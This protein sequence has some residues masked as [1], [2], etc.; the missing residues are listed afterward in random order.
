MA[1][2]FCLRC[3]C[4]TLLL[5]SASVLAVPKADEGRVK[6]VVAY[7][8]TH[9][10]VWPEKKG[11]LNL[12]TLGSDELSDMMRGIVRQAGKESKIRINAQQLGLD[13][14]QRCDVLYIRNIDQSDINE[15]LSGLKQWPILTIGDSEEFA[16]NGGMIGLY[17]EN[18]KVRFAV[19]LGAVKQ[20]GLLVKFQLLKLAKVIQ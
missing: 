6:A 5:L 17:T 15:V 8:I 12:C 20:A 10:V 16:H 7:K 3:Y 13:L 1:L 9:F 4:L 18:D 11:R 2:K 14:K 19:N